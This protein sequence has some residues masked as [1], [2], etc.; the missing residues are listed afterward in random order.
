MIDGK[1]HKH[2]FTKT[3]Q[4]TRTAVVIH[5]R[6]GEA[7]IEGGIENLIVLKT[8]QSSFEKFVG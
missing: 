3:G 8:A 4:H 1:P 2:A 5:P 7:S 6:G